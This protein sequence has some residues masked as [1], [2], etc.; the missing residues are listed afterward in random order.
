MAYPGVTVRILDESLNTSS[1]ELDSPAIGAML[2]AGGTHSMKLFAYGGPTGE[3]TVQGYYFVEN[4]NDWFSRLYNYY[5]YYYPGFSA[6]NGTTLAARDL[7]ANGVTGWTD[8]WYHVHNFL[9]Y[10]AG[11]YVSW[12]DSGGSGDFRNL[13]YDVIF[14]G[15]TAT[16]NNALVTS[17]VDERDAGPLPVFG[18]LGVPS[19]TAISTGMTVTSSPSNGENACAVFGEKKHFNAVGSA[20]TLIVSSLAPDVA[21]C[22][23]RTDRDSYPWFSPAGA[24]RGR[25]NNVVN[26]TKLLNES[27]KNI[28]YDAKINPVFAVPGEG[29]LLWGDKTLASQNSTLSSINVARL[30]I[31]LKRTLGPLARGVLFEQND[32]ITRASFRTAAESVLR[33]VVAARGITEFKVV[34]DDTNNTPDL[35]QNKIFVADIL[36]KPIPA[37]NFVRLT[38]TNKNLSSTL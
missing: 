23:C 18:V 16:S 12:A 5:N 32:E 33:Q 19:T 25:I 37:I 29:T 30:F 38:L 17:A 26:L 21:G 2:G 36:I 8:E 3:E 28:L 6:T 27:Q 14:A 35:I 13:N 4:L 24:R 1:S 31:Y 7:A 34:C 10:G 20:N 11:C 22:I 9:Q 15:G